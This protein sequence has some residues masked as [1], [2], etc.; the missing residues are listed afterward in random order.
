MLREYLNL[1]GQ[2]EAKE[3][4]EH[5]STQLQHTRTK[6]QVRPTFTDSARPRPDAA[7][8]V[9]IHVYILQFAGIEDSLY[10]LFF[11]NSFV[12]LQVDEVTDLL[13]SFTSLSLQKQNL[14]D[15]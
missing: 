4:L 3:R 6:E 15:R 2:S 1:M 9:Y 8:H 10:V 5:I 13:A 11:I 14:G 12:F 7:V